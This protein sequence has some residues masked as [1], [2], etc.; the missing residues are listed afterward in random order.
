MGSLRKGF[1]AKTGSE[2]NGGTG[3]RHDVCLHAASKSSEMAHMN[4]HL[5]TSAV[6]LNQYCDYF[7][8]S[9][10]LVF[11]ERRDSEHDI[12]SCCVGCGGKILFGRLS[13]VPMWACAHLQALIPVVFSRC[14]L[15]FFHIGKESLQ[16]PR[17]FYFSLCNAQTCLLSCLRGFC[18]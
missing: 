2:I 10:P 17:S 12:H 18:K 4:E 9:P 7:F 15:A 3:W 11:S 8:H 14:H 1:R 13:E 16:K 6:L 5:S